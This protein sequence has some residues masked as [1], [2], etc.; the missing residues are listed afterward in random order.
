MNVVDCEGTNMGRKVEGLARAARWGRR[1]GSDWGEGK[2][3]RGGM[4]NLAH[5]CENVQDL[6][7]IVRGEIVE[8]RVFEGA[9]QTG[10]HILEGELLDGRDPEDSQQLNGVLDVPPS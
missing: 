10:A 6:C 7:G 1:T 4:V 9:E 8:R 5:L 2:R 3:G